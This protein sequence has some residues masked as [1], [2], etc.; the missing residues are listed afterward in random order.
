MIDL[1]KLREL[2]EK[3]ERNPND[4][5]K[6]I[7]VSSSDIFDILDHIA[8]LEDEVKEQCR[9]NGIGAEREAALLSKVAQL[10][11]DA[12]RLDWMIEQ[13]AYVVSD[14]TCCDGY[15]LNWARPDGTTWTQ[16]NEYETPR[17]AI[18]TAMESKHES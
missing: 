6:S 10:E 8:A 2:A 4:D 9:I 7:I 14:E 15:W 1:E 17:Q 12:G 3:S 5:W 13:R 18:D 11:K 16:A